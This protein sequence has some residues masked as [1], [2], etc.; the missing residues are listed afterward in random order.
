[1]I[2][3]TPYRRST[4]LFAALLAAAGCSNSVEVEPAAQGGAGGGGVSGGTAGTG[5]E[6]PEPDPTVQAHAPDETSVEVRFN[7]EADAPQ[8][9]SADAYVIA[10][11]QGPLHV[12]AVSAGADG[13][14]FTLTTEKQKLGVT[15]QLSVDVP[16]EAVDGLEDSFLAADTASF[17]ATDFSSPHYPDYTVEAERV[18]VGD[19]C[20]L[21]VEKGYSI[22]G[23]E[24]SAADFDQRIFPVETTLFTGPPDFDGNDRIVI[25]GLDGGDYYGGYFSPVNAYPEDDVYPQWG[26]H[27]NEM[28]LLYINV[29]GAH[30]IDTTHVVPHELQHLLYHERHG[31]QME[32]FAYHDEGLAEGAVLAVNGANDYAPYHYVTDPSGALGRGISLVNWEVGDYDQYARA[33]LF[34]AYVASR[35]GGVEGLGE[36]FDQDGHPEQIGAFL[37]SELGTDFMATYRDML[38]ATWVQA[39]SGPLGFE[40]LVHFTGAP[41]TAPVGTTSLQLEPFGGA[42]FPLAVAEVDYPGTQGPNIEYVG[43]DGDGNVDLDAPFDVDGGV[44][45]ALNAHLE[46]VDFPAEPSGPDLPA[47]S[48]SSNMTGGAPAA[49]Q[50]LPPVAAHPHPT[51]LDPPPV[52]PAYRQHLDKWR[53]AR[54]RLRRR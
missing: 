31:L 47:A 48:P 37:A 7:V 42:L 28:E 17:W 29:A 52:H 35:L 1:M 49:P 13:R 4:L 27:S 8:L 50:Y 53:E 16:G 32:Y 9:S 33:Y 10:S 43:I 18:V 19:H 41:P 26:I 12:A 5:A 14:T 15:Y 46:V 2:H 20:V 36:I 25:L 45:V 54:Q 51:W 39:T 3:G 24:Q 44:L 40:Q 38:I 6:L 34:W 21:Y 11:E 23:A 30:A 22:A